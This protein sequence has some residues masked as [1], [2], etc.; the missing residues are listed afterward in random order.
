MGGMGV[1]GMR[2][3]LLMRGGSIW[4]SEF[5]SFLGFFACLVVFLWGREVGELGT[6]LAAIGSRLNLQLTSCYADTVP[7]RK[8]SL[9]RI[10]ESTLYHHGSC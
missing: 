10:L 3:I 4:R 7:K 6:H 5:C 2:S 8:T 1:R 9:V